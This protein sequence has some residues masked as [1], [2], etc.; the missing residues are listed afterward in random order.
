MGVSEKVHML[1]LFDLFSDTV[2]RGYFVTEFLPTRGRIREQYM[3]LACANLCKSSIQCLMYAYISA[4]FNVLFLI[5]CLR[6]HN[7]LLMPLAAHPTYEVR[8]VLLAQRP[9]VATNLS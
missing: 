6:T 3:R 8:W 4:Y 9:L 5:D 7:H 2:S 1:C